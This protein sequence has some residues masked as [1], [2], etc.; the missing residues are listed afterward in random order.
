MVAVIGTTMLAPA[1][2]DL[3]LTLRGAATAAPEQ[4]RYEVYATQLL[5]VANALA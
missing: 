1:S 5:A 4:T 3:P 2:T